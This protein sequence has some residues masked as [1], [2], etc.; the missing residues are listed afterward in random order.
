YKTTR[1]VSVAGLDVSF[2]SRLELA[3]SWAITSAHGTPAAHRVPRRALSRDSPRQW[4]ARHLHRRF[5]SRAVPRRARVGRRALPRAVPCLLLDGQSLPPAAGDARG[6]SLA[7]HAA[8][9]R[10]L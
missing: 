5:R 6:Q 9:Q 1:V 10:R 7:G 2:L 3:G 8:A 4:A